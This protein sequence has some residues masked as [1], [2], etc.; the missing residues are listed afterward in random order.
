MENATARRKVR[1]GVVVSTKMD[2]TIVVKVDRKAKHPLYGKPVIKAKRYMAHDESSECR[3]GDTVR[4]EECRPLSRKKRWALKE[5]IKRAPI[6][7]ESKG[8]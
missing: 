7:D 3:T 1:Y 2:K 5:V 8:E 4:I 6:L